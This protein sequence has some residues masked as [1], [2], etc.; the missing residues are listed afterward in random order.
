MA[1]SNPEEMLPGSGTGVNASEFIVKSDAA[2]A[3]IEI[4]T[5]VMFLVLSSLNM[6]EIRSM[7][8]PTERGLEKAFSA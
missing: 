6:D 5:R 8:S 2:A 4:V 3:T 7:F 1:I